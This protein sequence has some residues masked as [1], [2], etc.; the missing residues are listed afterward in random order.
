MKHFYA[1]NRPSRIKSCNLLSRFKPP[2]IPSRTHHHA[3]RRILRPLEMPFTH[4]PRNR[5]LQR[6][7]QIALQ[8]H[9]NR[10]RLRIPEPAIKLQ[11]HRTPRRHHQPAVKHALILRPFRLHPRYH[12]TRDMIHQPIPHVLI[13]NVSRS[14]CTHA[15]GIRPHIAIANSLMI[16][17]RH[18]RGNSFAVAQHEKGKFVACQE[19]FQHHPRARLAHHLPAQHFRGRAGRLFFTRRNHHAFARGQPVRLHH[20]RSMK[21][22]Q[23]RLHLCDRIA[24]RIRRRGNLMPLQ[25]FLRETLAAFQLCPSLRRPKYWPT[26][27]H[28]FVHYAQ[29]QR[30]FRT[31]HRQ[32]RP[33]FPPQSN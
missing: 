29:R 1:S 13:D 14:I 28:E 24:N 10:L 8:P 23:S 6:I 20:H 26:P 9:H 33:H 3:H 7:H 17:R 31:N 21:Q 22:R 5:C 4:P 12:R 30:Q 27:L 16:P 18:Q 11:H 2:R 25:K 32:V 19:F 15:S